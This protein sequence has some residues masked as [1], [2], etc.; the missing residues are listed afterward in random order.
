MNTV[1][2]CRICK[3]PILKGEG[4]FYKGMYTHKTCK[5]EAETYWWRYKV[6]IPKHS[7]NLRVEYA[8][9]LAR[10]LDDKNLSFIRNS[11]KKMKRV[12]LSRSQ[13]SF[14][15]E[16]LLEE[17]VLDIYADNT[18]SKLYKVNKKRLIEFLK[19]KEK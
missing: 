9:I 11:E 12:G 13:S 7:H 19:E 10:H 6:Q 14:A 1:R 3:V 2:R 17:W 16:K 18:Q 5:S 8:I 15:I 4:T